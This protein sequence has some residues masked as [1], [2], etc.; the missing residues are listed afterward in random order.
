MKNKVIRYLALKYRKFRKEVIV[1]NH[2]IKDGR[3]YDAG[4]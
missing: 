3:F 2:E 4:Y 1:L